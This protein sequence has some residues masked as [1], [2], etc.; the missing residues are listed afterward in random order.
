MFWP[1]QV[2]KNWSKGIL[3]NM[4]SLQR[5]NCA[6]KYYK[7]LRELF[8]NIDYMDGKFLKDFRFNLFQYVKE[9]PGCTYEGLIE[10]F[11]SPEETFCEYVGSKDDDYLI[12]CI[13]KKHFRG[14][15]KVGIIVA[16]I[17]SC[18]I[19]GLFYY[20]IYK[21]STNATINK[22]IIFVEEENIYE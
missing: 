17:C 13:N 2:K 5:K 20:R 21:E 18:L 19:W 1:M 11:G 3:F 9:H 10:E 22:K 15:M 14:W 12:S 4:A 7:I 16:C 8:L 6:Q